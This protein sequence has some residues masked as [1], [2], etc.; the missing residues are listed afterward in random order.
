MACLALL[1]SP[2]PL[3]AAAG[4]IAFREVAADW[5]LDFRHNAGF[6]GRHY[7]VETMGGGVVLFDYDGDGDEDAFFIDGGALPGYEGPVPRSRL[8]RND[9]GHSGGNSDSDG[10][11][12][13]DSPARFVDVTD[14]AGMD[15]HG[16]GIGG[17]AGDVDNDGDLDLYVTA[18][19]RNELF[20]NLGDGSFRSAGAER[21]VADPRW[22]AS[23]AFADLDLD[24]DLDLYVTNYTDFSIANHKPCGLS[25]SSDGGDGGTRDSGERGYCHPDMYNGVTDRLYLNDGSGFFTDATAASGLD[26]PAEAG[27]GVVVGDLD[28]DRWP[29]IYVANDKDPN[30]LFRNLG[31][32]RFEDESLLSGAAFDRSGTAEAGMGVELADLD[33]DGRQDLVVT[34]FALE[35]NAFYRNAGGGVFLDRRFPAGLAQPSL[36]RLA[37]GVNAFDA[38]L[39]GDLDLFVANGHIQPRAASIG[40]VGAYEQPNQLFEN[41]G[42][43]R[44]RERN[45]VGIGEVRTSRGSAV[46]DLDLDGDLDL[47]AVNSNQ[48]AEAYENRASGGWFALTLVAGSSKATEAAGSAAEGPE[49]GA[50]RRMPA[51]TPAHP[52]S[53]A[54]ACM[55]LPASEQCRPVAG[56]CFWPPSAAADR[57]V[58]APGERR[59]RER[60]SV[61]QPSRRR[62]DRCA[63]SRDSPSG[64]A[65]ALGARTFWSASGK[66]AAAKRRPLGSAPLPWSYQFT[67]R[68]RSL[69]AAN[70][71]G[72]DTN[73]AQDGDGSTGT[74]GDGTNA[75]DGAGGT[76]V[77]GAR[78]ELTAGETTQVRETRAGSSY[79]SQSTLAAFFGLGGEERIDRIVVRPPSNARPLVLLDL[80]SGRRALLRR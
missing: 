63:C 62:S 52:V 45:G 77:P 19:G 60:T 15:F 38:D 12:A 79:L 29:D 64:Q 21:G 8:L 72:R 50:S 22:S 4:E 76:A 57:K 30:L 43:G 48:V 61:L 53:A 13:G 78:V 23:A 24:G 49:T 28:G 20:L 40:E 26:G 58:R 80:P 6:T 42:G 56:A 59:R 75:A 47:V 51:G 70:T 39:D 3:G 71:P 11:G 10:I 46:A 69:T 37:F 74:A 41:L 5:G 25:G 68:Q 18:F 65:R 67:A 35:T 33:G 27:L 55:E 2:L 7:M 16:Y 73:V 44:F 9:A 54:Q 66:T 14:A 32:G 36:Q 31:D 17:A 1:G 34:N